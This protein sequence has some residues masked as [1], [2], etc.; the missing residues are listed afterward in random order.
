MTR[1]TSP[2][3]AEVTRLALT[4]QALLSEA[5]DAQWKP[6]MV[7]DKGE[8]VSGGSL[9]SRGQHSDPTFDTVADSRRLALR[10]A[11][12]TAETRLNALRSTLNEA[13][14]DLQTALDRWNGGN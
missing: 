6:S 7:V 4:L 12:L 2:T 8:S 10:A 5:S 9:A 11:V 13:A 1:L 14:V 3:V